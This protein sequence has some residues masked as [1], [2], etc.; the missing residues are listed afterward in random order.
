MK[1]QLLTLFIIVFSF[2]TASAVIVVKEKASVENNQIVVHD[3]VSNDKSWNGKRTKTKLKKKKRF[4][5]FKFLKLK[6]ALKKQ[7]DSGKKYDR[8]SLIAGIFA[9]VG[10]AA[11]FIGFGGLEL[12]LL[13]AG[14]VLGIIGLKRIK[15]DPDNLKGKGF[16]WTGIVGGI[17]GVILGLLLL[18]LLLIWVN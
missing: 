4:K 10:A 8:A 2:Q 13:L 9:I 14:G 3:K 18:L 1:L 16:A 7:K 6:R 11:M 12:L 17:I 5:F 15:K